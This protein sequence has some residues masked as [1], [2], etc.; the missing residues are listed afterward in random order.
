LLNRKK[1]PKEPSTQKKRLQMIVAAMPIKMKVA[2]TTVKVAIMT[3][4]ATETE[5]L[6]PNTVGM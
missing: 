1:P 3:V 5:T 4:R 6:H 2:V